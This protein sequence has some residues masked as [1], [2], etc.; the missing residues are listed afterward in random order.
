M[1]D[2]EIHYNNRNLIEQ[3]YQRQA[4]LESFGWKCIYVLSKDWLHQP[5]KV[6]QQIVKRLT[7]ERLPKHQPE[8]VGGSL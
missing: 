5:E 6:L 1:I 2:D 7:E 8:D 3:Y 4:I